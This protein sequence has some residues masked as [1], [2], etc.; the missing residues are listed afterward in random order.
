MNRQYGGKENNFE[1]KAVTRTK[2]PIPLVYT[3]N[4][5]HTRIFV[6]CYVL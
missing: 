6:V 2:Y 3:S 4:N 5:T 1:F